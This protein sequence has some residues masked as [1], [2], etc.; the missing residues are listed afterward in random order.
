MRFYE[1]TETYNID[2]IQMSKDF[3]PYKPPQLKQKI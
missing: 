2:A 1:K 3:Y